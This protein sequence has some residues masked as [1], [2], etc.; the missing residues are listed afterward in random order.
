MFLKS[1]CVAAVLAAWMVVPSA[2]DSRGEGERGSLPPGTSRDESRPSE[3]AIKGGSAA[4][5]KPGT[6]SIQ[7][8]GDLRREIAR[9]DALM[10]ALRD[11]CLRDVDAAAGAAGLRPQKPRSPAAN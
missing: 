1:L 8:E 2:Q 4:S 5:R 9:C 10:G 7:S 6:P 11:D 3:G